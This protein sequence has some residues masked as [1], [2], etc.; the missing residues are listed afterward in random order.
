MGEP[1]DPINGIRD[2]DRISI[3]GRSKQAN[4]IAVH[5]GQI[6]LTVERLEERLD[7]AAKLSNGLAF[8]L[9]ADI[10]RRDS[11]YR[12]DKCTEFL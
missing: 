8:Q 10:V 6:R 9:I 5:A 11:A 1:A 2:G 7:L 12:I 4:R 3:H